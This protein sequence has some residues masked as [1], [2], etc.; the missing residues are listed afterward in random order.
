M[1]TVRP[2]QSPKASFCAPSKL[3][4]AAPRAPSRDRRAAPPGKYVRRRA[5]GR[6]AAGGGGLWWVC[7]GVSETGGG[8]HG[9]GCEVGPRG[10]TSPS[11][12]ARASTTPVA[13]GT[14]SGTASAAVLLLLAPSRHAPAAATA[15]TSS[16]A[17]SQRQ[18]TR[19]C[20]RR[21][22]PRGRGPRQGASG[23]GALTRLLSRVASRRLQER[24][25]REAGGAGHVKRTGAPCT[26]R[27]RLPRTC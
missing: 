10:L 8:L 21:T 1:S 4:P 27:P 14:R 25:A 13:H 26:L 3:R 5:R 2:R 20:D 9:A 18:R 23:V 7:G 24:K 6:C 15:H 12:A 17:A 19:V 11:K 22:R 16:A